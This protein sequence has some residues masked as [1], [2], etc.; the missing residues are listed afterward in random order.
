MLDNIIITLPEFVTVPLIS[1]TVHIVILMGTDNVPGNLG[2]GD[3][4]I[5]QSWVFASQKLRGFLGGQG[6]IFS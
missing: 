2:I 6:A 1:I 4:N 5:L 3:D